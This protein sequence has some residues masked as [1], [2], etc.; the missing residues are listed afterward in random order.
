[1]LFVFFQLAIVMESQTNAFLIRNSLIELVV[2]VTVGTVKTT[3]KELIVKD[4]KIFIIEEKKI[5]SV[6]LVTVTLLVLKL[7]Y[8]I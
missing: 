7:L 2:V 1:M 3:L 8:L 4:A 6:F 5:E